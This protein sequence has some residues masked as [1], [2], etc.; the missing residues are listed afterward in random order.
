[1]AQQVEGLRRAVGDDLDGLTRR[2]VV[3]DRPRA[4]VDAAGER[5]LREARADGGRQVEHGRT[6]GQVLL[7]SVG[8]LDRD[9]R[10]VRSLLGC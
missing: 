2:H 9:L 5:G 7:A 3:V 8:Q 1:V 6:L 4:R 10:H